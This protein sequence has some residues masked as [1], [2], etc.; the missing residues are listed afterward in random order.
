M[1]TPFKIPQSVLVV[2]YTS[3]L[4]VL[5][6]RRADVPAGMPPF[7]QSVTGSKDHTTDSWLE[8]A[9]REVWEETGID[10][11][12]GSALATALRDWELE[13]IYS[14]YPRWLHRY[15]P[16]VSHNTERVFGLQVPIGTSVQINP[17]EHTHYQWVPYQEA[18]DSC[19]SASNAEAILMLP[20]FANLDLAA[21][22]EDE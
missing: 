12:V 18:A 22:G 20:R 19:F 11:R 21:I 17:R 14:I 15:A 2:I 3:K 8:T 9:A 13:N 10:C 7:W 5:L 1:S 16:G 6:I 4:N